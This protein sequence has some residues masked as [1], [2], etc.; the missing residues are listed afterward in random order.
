[1]EIK[2]YTAEELKAMTAEEREKLQAD[3][4]AAKLAAETVLTD[5]EQVAIDA[6]H[7]AAEEVTTWAQEFRQKH[8]ISV[9]VALVGGGYIIWQV[10]AAVARALG[11]A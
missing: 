6:E 11:V 9:W 8:G 1:M 7:E 4:A 10:G 2:T 3:Y 5:I